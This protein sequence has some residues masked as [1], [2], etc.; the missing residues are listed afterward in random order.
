M[1]IH[2]CSCVCGGICATERPDI[3]VSSSGTIHLGFRGRP[4]TGTGEAMIRLGRLNNEPQGSFRL[5]LSA[6]G[7]TH[8]PACP[9]RLF[10]GLLG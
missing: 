7:Y 9:E 1:Y 3:W 4:F 8:T 6:L 5:H 2:V 10:I